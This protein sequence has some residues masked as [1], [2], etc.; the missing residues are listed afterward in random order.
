MAE[1]A[2]GYGSEFQLLRCL[3]HHRNALNALIKE[4]TGSES[5]IDW[6]DYPIDLNR[7]SMDG[8]LKG[9]ECFKEHFTP[10]RYKAIQ[11]AWTSFWP[12]RGNTMNW[13]G[14]FIQ[15]GVWYFVEAKANAQEAYQEC[16]ASCIDSRN[17]IIAAFR[18]T[19][20][21][22]G[23]PENEEWIN[24]TCYQLAN[25]LAFLYFCKLQGI[26]ARLLYIGFVNGYDRK[27][28]NTKEDWLKI[29]NDEYSALGIPAGIIDELVLHIHPNCETTDL[30]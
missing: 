25:R 20:N 3:G 4:K 15:N 29:W 26:E 11:K 8:E 17:K 22:F 2:M 27:S 19:Q 13:D 9:I 21:G 23:I 10:S 5:A 14:I 12:G 24:S 18:T 6:L 16:G 7:K 30:R 1:M 28:V